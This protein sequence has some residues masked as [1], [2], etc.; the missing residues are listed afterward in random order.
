MSLQARLNVDL[1]PLVRGGQSAVERDAIYSTDGGRTTPL[2]F[3]T[4]LGKIVATGKYT[5][6]IDETAVNGTAI[7]AGIYIGPSI[8]AADIVAGDVENIPLLVGNGVY[9][10]F[11]KLVIEN[12]KLLTTIIDT[13]TVNARTVE[14]QLRWLGIF[15]VETV[16]ITSFEN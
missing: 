9:L 13:G 2:L 12:S 14:D 15:G 4:V 5:A 1:T 8:P 11:S 7:P 3:G 6:F 16:D 10:D